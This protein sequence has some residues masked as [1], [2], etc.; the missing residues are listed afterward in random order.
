VQGRGKAV[1]GDEYQTWQVRTRALDQKQQNA[2]QQDLQTKVGAYASA[3][4]AEHAVGAAKAGAHGALGGSH[5]ALASVHQGHGLLWRA[6]LTGLSH[7]AAVHACQK[8]A[9]GHGGCIVIS[10]E[11]QS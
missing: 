7:E 2:L 10:P 1:N 11:S 3:A 4:Q 8:L 6:R 9:H 5:P